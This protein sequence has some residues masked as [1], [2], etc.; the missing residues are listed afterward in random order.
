MFSSETSRSAEFWISSP[1]LKSHSHH[2]HISKID[3]EFW[4]Q[5]SPLL[6]CPKAFVLQG[7]H[8]VSRCSRGRRVSSRQGLLLQQGFKATAQQKL[9]R[10]ET[11]TQTTG[12]PGPECCIQRSPVKW[13]CLQVDGRGWIHPCCQ[14]WVETLASGLKPWQPLPQLPLLFT[15]SPG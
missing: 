10:K 7:S 3:Q 9:C 12:L 15:S 2:G 11:P 8:D 14:A 4:S 6:R 5:N 13:H 1:S